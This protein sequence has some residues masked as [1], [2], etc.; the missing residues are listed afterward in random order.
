MRFHPAPTSRSCYR[1]LSF[2][3]GGIIVIA[4]AIALAI[5][6]HPLYLAIALFSLIDFALA[7]AFATGRMGPRAARRQAEASGAADDAAAAAAP[8][9]SNDPYARED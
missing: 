7:G 2:V 3:L 9:P 6:L 8:D 4:I 5:L 1:I